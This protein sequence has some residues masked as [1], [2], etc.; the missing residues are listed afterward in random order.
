MHGRVPM[1][2][3]ITAPR[4]DTAWAPSAAYPTLDDPGHIPA[5]ADTGTT[6]G[7]LVTAGWLYYRAYQ[8][9]FSRLDG[10]TCRFRPTCSAFALEAI[11]REGALG[12]WLAFARLHRAHGPEH[13]YPMEEPPFLSDPLKAYTFWMRRPRLDDFAA[14]RDPAHAWYQHV[15]AAQALAARG[16]LPIIGSKN[17]SR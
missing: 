17:A 9:T 13:H 14:Y 4:D 3:V 11:T 6:S 1:T 8:A 16:P 5:E 15:R 10:A 7:P 12:L 2:A